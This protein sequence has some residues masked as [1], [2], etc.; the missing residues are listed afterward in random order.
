MLVSL[1]EVLVPARAQGRGVAAFNAAHL[2]HAEALVAAAEETSLPLVLQISEN[3]IRWHAG[4][5]PLAVAARVLAERAAVPVVLHLDHAV[6]VALV[7]EALALGFT[8]VMYDGSTLEEEQNLSTTRSVAD[9]CHALGIS[10]EAEVG[11]IGGK[12]GVHAPG[13]R[14]L[15]EVAARFAAETGVDALAVAVGSSHAML[16]R[17]AELDLDLVARISEAVPVPLV[18]HGSSGVSDDGIVAA[19]QAG[20]TKINMSTHLNRVFTTAV[21]SRLAQEP[22]LVDSR[23]YLG[24]ARDAMRE[25]AVRL[26]RLISGPGQP[27]V[28]GTPPPAS[29]TT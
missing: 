26:Q 16:D 5:A 27:P 2:E 10:V 11:E 9:R 23:K 13:A 6:S 3:A 1:S 7:D 17:T 15:P 8:S 21:R 12:D 24:P 22:G 29:S 28:V 4:L 19:V 25:E 18:L 20:M 14:T